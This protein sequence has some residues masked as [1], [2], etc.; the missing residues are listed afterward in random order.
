MDISR[1]TLLQKTSYLTPEE[2]ALI[3]QA[4]DFAHT[5]H[6]GQKRKSGEPYVNHVQATAEILADLHADAV[7][8]TAGLLHDVLEDTPVSEETL[9]ETFGDEV[10]TLVKGVTKLGHL[11]YQ[12]VQRYSESLRKF[13][14]ASAH[15]IR[16]VAIKLAD[17]LHNMKTLEHIEP[18]KQQRIALETLEIHAR[19]ADRLGMGRLKAELE[20]LGFAFAYPDEYE[21]TKQLLSEH[22]KLGEHHLAQVAKTLKEELSILEAQ[23]TSLNYRVKHLYSTWIKLKGNG[24]DI[25]KIYDIFALR[26][27]VPTVGDCYQALGIIHG[28]YKPIPG[29]F[30]DYIAMPKPNGYQSLHTAVFDGKGGIVEIQIRTMEMHQEAEYGIYSHVGYKEQNK[31]KSLRNNQSRSNHDWTKQLLEAQREIANHD[32]FM[33]HLKLDFFEKRVFV[34]TPKGDVIELPLGACVLDFAYA[35]HSDIGNHTSGARVNHKMV[36]LDTELVQG[37]VVEIQTSEKAK[38]NRKWLD[39][40]KT[41]FAKQQI[42]KYFREHGGIIDRMFIS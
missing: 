22:Q 34:Y 13:F 40:C 32:D 19:L 7:T 15:D 14:I 23:I 16:V 26:I 36:S 2:Q 6:H 35:I 21:K 3:I 28:L 4:L 8:I 20:D 39:H 24:F 10:T 33:K 38:P 31:K 1:E 25:T 11:K 17:R 30:K 37:D 9:C 29:R 27:I 18:R 5:A 41:T 12:G 42:R